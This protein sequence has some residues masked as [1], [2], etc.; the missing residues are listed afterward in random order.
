MRCCGGW[1]GRLILVPIYKTKSINNNSHDGSG[2]AGTQNKLFGN[3]PPRKV[4]SHE[5]SGGGVLV[6]D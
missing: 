6:L 5:M 1:T 2:V 4:F 3:I